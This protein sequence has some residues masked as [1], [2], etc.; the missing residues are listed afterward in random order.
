MSGRTRDSAREL[1]CGATTLTLVFSLTSCSDEPK[2][3]YA[4]VS[5]GHSFP[6]ETLT[7]WVSYADQI[8]VVTV[9]SDRALPSEGGPGESGDAEQYQGR[10]ATF[11]VE[12]TVWK[13]RDS[14]ERRTFEVPV[15]G[16][17]RKDGAR[18]PAVPDGG[19]RFEVGERFLLPISRDADG[20]VA[21]LSPS[22][23]IPLTS[24]PRGLWS[25]D[26]AAAKALTGKD[27]AQV[28]AT[29]SRTKPD[30]LAVK[31]HL[32][33]PWQRS[34]KVLDVRQQSAS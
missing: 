10:A 12:S 22:A 29:L 6:S 31:Y 9:T 30:A 8:S 15:F 2:S 19:L 1:L 3:T 24:K 26:S 4:V 32:L 11:V 23:A 27:P 16:W 5:G 20:K 13:D 21:F 33:P 7:D 17:V 34:Q 14:P 18:T 25:A 28:T